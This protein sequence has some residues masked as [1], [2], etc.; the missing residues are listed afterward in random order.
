MAELKKAV[1]ATREASFLLAVPERR[2]LRWIAARLPRRVLPDDLT[3]LG[4][5]AAFGVC[6]AYQLANEDV[7]WLWIASGLLILQWLGDSL[8]G[9]LAR[10]RGCAGPSGRPTA[11]TWITSSMRSQPPRSASGLDSRR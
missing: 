8:D 3:A 1:E 2:L 11:T 5:L 7:A 9:T 10:V 6:A 4:V